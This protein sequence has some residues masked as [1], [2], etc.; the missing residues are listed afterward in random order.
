MID[1]E[2][3][4]RVTLA[5]NDANGEPTGRVNEICVDRV[6]VMEPTESRRSKRCYVLNGKTL[7][8]G[9]LR[10]PL[11]GYHTHYDADPTRDYAQLAID[12]VARVVNYL[13]GSGWEVVEA[14]EGL[15]EICEKGRCV[16]AS[17]LFQA[18]V[19]L[20]E[21]AQRWAW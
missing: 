14:E 2:D 16:T 5:V 18:W 20:E 15:F 4:V 19:A 1:I 12:D 6:L 13:L 7:W 9:R 3:L 10:L 8:L 11:Y 21:E 17:D